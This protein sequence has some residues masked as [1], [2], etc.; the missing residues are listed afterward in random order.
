MRARDLLCSYIPPLSFLAASAVGLDIS[1]RAIRF[2][3]LAPRRGRPTLKRYGERQLPDGAVVAGEIKN[4][5]AL[6]AALARFR[7]DFGLKRA[8]ISLSAQGGRVL[9]MRV[10][11][12]GGA[13]I[14][15][16]ALREFENRAP[17]PT[18]DEILD[19]SFIA[20]SRPQSA[21]VGEVD[22]YISVLP[23]AVI[24]RYRELL[25]DVG[26]AALS[27]ELEAHA[28]KRALLAPDDCG[29]YMLLDIGA[30]RT[31]VSVV[32][33]GVVQ[34]VATIGVGGAFFTR[35]AARALRLDCDTARRLKERYGL[36]HHGGGELFAA[37]APAVGALRDEIHERYVAW[38]TDREASAPSA[39]RRI[40]KIIA[41]GGESNVPG[42][43][44][45]LSASLRVPVERGDPWTNIMPRR[46]YPPDL[47]S[48]D[49]IR[50]VTA[51]GSALR[52]YQ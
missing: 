48:N 52:S 23:K 2:A 22:A 47:P 38:Y 11:H 25:E 16:T 39:P 14:R 50:Y 41:C 15:G 43:L 36:T 26:I 18:R 33:D 45:Y 32:S 30:M 10:P 20:C 4:P 46:E 7:G 6:R 24:D 49:A 21:G 28:I 34:F 40:E 29:T 9:M 17:A 42:L 12:S 31:G 19:Y 37:L 51:L 35:V 8:H 1:G 3:E 5:A 27:F 44:P 13:D